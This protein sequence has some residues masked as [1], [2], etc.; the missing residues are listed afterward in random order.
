MDNQEPLIARRHETPKTKGRALRKG[1]VAHRG[2]LRLSGSCQ[3]GFALQ[4][5]K[6]HL[7]CMSATCPCECHKRGG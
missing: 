1:L 3:K 6:F 2:A 7:H 5:M 4:S